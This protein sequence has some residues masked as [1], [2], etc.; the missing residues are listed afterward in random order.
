MAETD[1]IRHLQVRQNDFGDV[2]LRANS[3]LVALKGLQA[4]PEKRLFVAES[5]SEVV[6]IA[7][8]W[9]DGPQTKTSCPYTKIIIRLLDCNFT[10]VIVEDNSSLFGKG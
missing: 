2:F 10:S 9:V 5:H 8:L 1:S 3:R 6:K 7:M 4:I